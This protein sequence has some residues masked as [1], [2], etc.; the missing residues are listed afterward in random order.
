MTWDPAQ[1][2]TFGGHRIRPAIDLLSAVAIE[3]PRTILD[4][5]CG[6]GN[7][8]DF[9]ATR[10][11]KARIVGLDSSNEMLTKAHQEHPDHEWIKGDV[12]EWKPD[13]PFD[14]VYSNAVLHWV[15]R[16]DILFPDLLTWV[17]PGGCLAIQMPRNFAAPSHTTVYK[18]IREGAWR[19]RLE[20][21]IPDEPTKPPTFYYDLLT[22]L[23]RSLDLWETE[24]QQ[25]LEGK[26]PVPEY[27]KG[28]WL[29]PFLD[30]LEEPEKS[31]FEEAYK[32]NVLPHYPPQNDGKTLFP[33]RRLFIVAQV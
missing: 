15:P 31:N 19:D 5:G 9:F 33:F 8:L 26:N 2:L 1:Y 28:S 24:Y 17:K 18:T 23:V 27:V 11:P 3:T 25:I 20:P 32:A 16:H 12:C 22:P 14:L 13:E 29:K 4:L 10:W 6:T 21:M 7:M 30:A